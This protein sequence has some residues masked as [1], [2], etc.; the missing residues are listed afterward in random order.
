LASV[1]DFDATTLTPAMPGSAPFW[2]VG[3]GAAA[4][5]V[6]V[7]DRAAERIIDI[8]HERVAEVDDV[9]GLTVDERGAEAAVDRCRRR[10]GRRWGRFGMRRDGRADHLDHV[11]LVATV[12]SRPTKR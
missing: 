1:I 5:A 3:G 2:A 10:R 11:A 7:V 8:R 4:V 9:D 6:V 12:S